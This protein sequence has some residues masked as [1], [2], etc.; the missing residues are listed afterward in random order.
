MQER[1][2][3]PQS[4]NQAQWSLRVRDAFTLNN[5][6]FVRKARTIRIFLSTKSKCVIFT[7]L[8]LL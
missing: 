5:T 6:I 4:S 8:M 3:K 7:R 2:L 1:R